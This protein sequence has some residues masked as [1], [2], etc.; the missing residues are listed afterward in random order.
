[1]PLKRPMAGDAEAPV[2]MPAARK[3]FGQH[4]LHDPQVIAR[5]MAALQARPGEAMVEI[6][7]GRGALTRALLPAIKQLDAVELDRD[8]IPLLQGEMAALG[9]LHIHQGDALKFDFCTLVRD[10]HKVRVVGNLPYNIST[11]L[12]FHLIDQAACIRDMHFMVQK[13]VAL[14]LAAGPGGRD[15]GRLGIMVQYRCMVE[16]LFDVGAG[17]FSP[18]PKVTS[19]FIRLIP[20]AVPAAKVNSEVNFK[21]LVNQAFSRRRKTLRNALKGLL[22]Q[23]QI[24]AQGV[25]ASVRPETLP[26][27]AFARLSNVME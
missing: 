24:I 13:E 19:S 8:L 26:L 12:L 18:P 2:T 25:D 22:T 7:P 9:E 11:P 10:E 3:R 14:R 16:I 4:F 20:R 23:E 21:Q 27:E 6:G 17:A 1:M 5:I 15:Y